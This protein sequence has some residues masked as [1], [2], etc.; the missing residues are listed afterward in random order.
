MRSDTNVFLAE[1]FNKAIQWGMDNFYSH[2]LTMDQDSIFFKDSFKKYRNQIEGLILNKEYHDSYFSPT[3]VDSVVNKKDD[4]ESLI[5]SVP[6]YIPIIKTI[7]SGCVYKIDTLHKIG[8]FR[9]DYKIDYIDFEVCCRLNLSRITGVKCNNIILLQEFGN[10]LKNRFWYT[11]NYSPVRLYY[12]TR[13]RIIF[14]KEYPTLSSVSKSVPLNTK[15]II[16]ILLSEK[17]KLRKIAS[18]IRGSI[19]GVTFRTYNY[20]KFFKI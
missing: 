11:L 20:E 16:K 17:Q 8:A 10:T 5:Q 14:R 9:E 3:I 4:I 6:T 1:A 7:T 13:N 18:I 12:Q 2:I 15:L 19:D